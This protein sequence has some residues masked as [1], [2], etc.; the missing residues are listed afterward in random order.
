MFAMNLVLL[1]CAGRAAKAWRHGHIAGPLPDGFVLR[2]RFYPHTEVHVSQST[3][4]KCGK[5]M[6]PVSDLQPNDRVLVEGGYRQDGSIE[7]RKITLYSSKSECATHTAEE[8]ANE[9]KQKLPQPIW[10]LKYRSGVFPLPREQWF[11]AG[12]LMTEAEEKPANPIAEISRDWLVAVYFNSKV[13]KDSDVVQRM[14][15]SGC[16]AAKSLMPKDESAPPLGLFIAWPAAPGPVARA[17]EHLNARYP[18]RFVWNQGG[19]EKDMVFTVNYCE[20]AS[21]LANVRWFAGPR[22]PDIGREFPR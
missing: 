16:Y 22:W 14:P 15:R 18:V 12:F 4:V 2:E 17:A 3:R 11:K 10:D 8:G 19:A 9:Y 1:A 13:Q 20:Y 5:Q 6:V 7:A 21:F